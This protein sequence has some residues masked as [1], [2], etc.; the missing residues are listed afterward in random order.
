MKGSEMRSC[1]QKLELVAIKGAGDG[2][3]LRQGDR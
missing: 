2:G 3:A 1:H